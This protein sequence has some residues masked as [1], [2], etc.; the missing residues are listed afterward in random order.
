MLLRLLLL[1]VP[2]RPFAVKIWIYS[3]VRMQVMSHIHCVGVAEWFPQ[4]I[5]QICY[6]VLYIEVMAFN[7]AIVVVLVH[8]R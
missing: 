5:L 7:A 8:I 2:R 3:L 4:P 1:V 6:S